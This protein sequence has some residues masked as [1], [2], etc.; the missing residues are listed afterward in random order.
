[1]VQISV[2]GNEVTDI[3]SKYL[4]DDMPIINVNVS[5]WFYYKTGLNN[6]K[7]NDWLNFIIVFVLKLF[8]S[9]KLI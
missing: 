7:L 9:I 1:M 4:S 2:Y 5:K 6:K 8:Y 3:S